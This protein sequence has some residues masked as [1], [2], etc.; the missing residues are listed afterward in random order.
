VSMLLSLTLFEKEPPG[1][2]LICRRFSSTVVTATG[3]AAGSI[4]AALL[5]PC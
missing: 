1:L 5:V 2:A 3:S 4:A